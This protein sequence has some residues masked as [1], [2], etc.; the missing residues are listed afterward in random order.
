MGFPVL[1]GSPQTNV[2]SEHVFKVRVTAG[3][4]SAFT[5]RAKDVTVTRPSTTTLKIALPMAYAEVTE[6]HV[7]RKAAA[8]AA[9]LEWIITTNSVT[10]ASDPHVILT[11]IESDTGAATTPADGDVAYIT[12]GLSQ[13]KLNDSFTGSG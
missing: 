9:G 7:G 5:Y 12:L 2:Y 11:S 3:A 1:D 10:S 4:A 6:F 8:A 13:D